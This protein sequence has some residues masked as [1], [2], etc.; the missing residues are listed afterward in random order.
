VTFKSPDGLFPDKTVTVV[1]NALYLS[2]SGVAASYLSD[3]MTEYAFTVNSSG[4]WAAS[5]TDANGILE[6]DS[7]SASGSA[8][9]T[10][11]FKF[12]L[13]QRVSTTTATDPKTA[14]VTFTTP[15]GS[16]EYAQVT[17]TGHAGYLMLAQQSY[18][19]SGY[20]A[21]S[22]DV[23]VTTNIPIASL[24]CTKS[25]S[26]IKSVS[27][28]AT[29][30]VLRVDV[31]KNNL[32]ASATTDII[33]KWGSTTLR[34]LSVTFPISPVDVRR[35]VTYYRTALTMTNQKVRSGDYTCPAGSSLPT[36]QAQAETY[37]PAFHEL[38]AESNDHGYYGI[39]WLNCPAYNANY[40]Y[41]L[42]RDVDTSYIS[43]R[44]FY[45]EYDTI[46]TSSFYAYCVVWNP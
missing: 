9:A 23:G 11:Q 39:A 40:W 32:S 46:W 43:V 44:R 36:T 33:V 10:G 25:H 7:W 19:T 24:S 15:D 13:V 21:H 6:S 41:L 2:T 22:F 30:P 17:I 4:P 45:W 34:T 29:G 37:L 14:T 12:K 3:G 38:C 8:S 16:Y 27:I 26:M 5:V 35:G 20:P 28:V 1:A 42:A 31:A 18:T